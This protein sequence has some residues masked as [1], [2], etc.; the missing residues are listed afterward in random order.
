MPAAK[1]GACMSTPGGNSVSSQF[2][3]DG[4]LRS[5]LE[6][7]PDGVLIL[8]LAG[9]V[10]FVNPTG[11]RMLGRDKAALLGAGWIT[12]WAEPDRLV[13]RAALESA[14][15]GE[16]T[17]RFAAPAPPAAGRARRLDNILSPLRDD[18]GATV[19]VLVTLRDVTDLEAA[20]LAA[21]A[22]ERAAAQEASV[23]RSVAEMAYLTSWD[24]DF[25]TNIS[26][27]GEAGVQAMHGGPEHS[28]LTTEQ[29]LAMYK[30]EDQVRIRNLLERARLYGEPFRFDAAVT[31]HDGTPGWVREFGEPIYEDGVC[32]GI[33]GAG[34]DVSD[35]MAA[36]EN[37]RSAQQ[38]LDLAVRL[39]GME[40]YELDFDRRI[41]IHEGPSISIFE[42]PPRFENL[43]PEPFDAV[44]SPDHAR[45]RAEWIRAK[46]SHTP[47]RSEFRVRLAG[48]RELWVYCVAEI[49]HEGGRPRRLV[50]AIMDITE[51]KRSELETLQAMAQMRAHE[52]R[53]KLLLDELN[54]R[55][56]N[57]LTAVQSVALQTLTDVRA[58]LEARDL[59]IE[60]LLALSNTHNLLVKRAWA[61]ASFREL[62]ETA[63][64][65]YGKT[66]SYDGP[67]LRVDPNFAVSLGMA[68]HELATN[69]LK[70]GSW[71]ADGQVKIVTAVDDADVRILWRESGGPP[72]SAPT[73]RGFGSRL[74]QRGVAGELG[75][76]VVLDFASDGLICKIQ[77]PLSAR[78]R[79][80]HQV[81]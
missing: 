45:I 81:V 31:R 64:K 59:F 60:R 43:W 53:Q 5:A 25:R 57:T 26:R 50:G 37:I 67:D 47:F 27:V 55:V 10:Q 11:V 21:E 36:Q 34:M 4:F 17:P 62:T 42:S 49:V 52:E 28:E 13:A 41:V 38:R 39:A 6:N 44:D 51:R 80:I 58:P 40:V 72:V 56:K 20:R 18:T 71:R 1:P 8:D 7:S 63:L 35:E 22:R 2:S 32:V 48:G 46:E 23:L 24:L 77:A 12:L 73:R 79:A 78:L 3:A 16:D 75:G 29:G 65:P 69:A 61:S 76:T 54:H 74:L 30:P 19:A 33:R 14:A 70:H 9:A 68:L 66:Y 15:R